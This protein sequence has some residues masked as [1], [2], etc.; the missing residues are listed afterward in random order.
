M[1]F[2]EQSAF[3][4]T[5]HL[6]IRGVNPFLVPENPEENEFDLDCDHYIVAFDIF[7]YSQ[8]LY[9]VDKI[10]Y[11]LCLP[12]FRIYYLEPF[13][14]LGDVHPSGQKTPQGRHPQAD[15]PGKEPTWADTPLRRSLQWKVH[16]LLECILLC[17]TGW[18][19][20]CHFFSTNDKARG[21]SF[22]SP[23][24]TFI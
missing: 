6:C 14:L 7:R 19:W 4:A 17:E 21:V 18:K 15:I 3:P 1:V 8:W 16:I 5:K 24:N 23:Q 9:W 20:I 13:C 10:S 12:F 22:S 11:I 2:R